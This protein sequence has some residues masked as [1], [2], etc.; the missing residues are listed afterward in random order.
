M[1]LLN[2]GS[3]P[4]NLL[5]RFL[6]EILVLVTV[7]IWS[8][9]EWDGWMGTVMAFALP[10]GL[11]VVWGSFTVPDDPSRSGKAPVPTP[12]PLRLMIELAILFF[13]VWCLYDLGRPRLAL[14][15]GLMILGH[16]IISLDRIRWLIK[17]SPAG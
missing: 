5:F 9:N 11:A 1:N 6:L 12:G 7:A 8:W 15:F 13:A 14:I 16:Y 2:L 4:L 17:K 3:H 10:F